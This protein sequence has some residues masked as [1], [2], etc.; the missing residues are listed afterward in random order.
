MSGSQERSTGPSQ[1]YVEIGVAL[2]M[3]VFGAIVVYGA[4]QVGIGWGIEGPRA[5]F[6]PFY[7]GLII[8]G[9]SLVNLYNARRM[10][11]YKGLFAE[12]SQLRQVAKVLVPATV[13]VFIIPYIGIY[14]ASALLIGL[15]MRWLGGYGWIKTLSLAIGMPLL[16]FVVFE[17]WFLVALPKGPLEAWLG[18]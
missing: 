2:A 12:W 17:R 5:G 6:L 9:G 13:Y 4:L 11:D 16:T 15:F 14:V 10:A 1:D 7:I 18:L 3:L 8:M